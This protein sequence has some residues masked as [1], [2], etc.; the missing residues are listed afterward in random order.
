MKSFDR[1]FQ[2]SLDYVKSIQVLILDVNYLVFKMT[3]HKLSPPPPPH[4]FITFKNKTSTCIY[5]H[6]FCHPNNNFSS[7]FVSL[8][9]EF[10][11]IKGEGLLPR[12]DHVK[13]FL[14]NMAR[15]CGKFRHPWYRVINTSRSLKFPAILLILY[16]KGIKLCKIS[17]VSHRNI[18]LMSHPVTLC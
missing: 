17:I 11:K 1:S 12:H 15:G 5:S 2:F 6:I 7:N 18:F 4:R 10:S 3:Q 13:Y 14:K 8:L 9:F 16:R